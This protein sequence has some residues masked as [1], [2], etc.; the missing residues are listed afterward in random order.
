MAKARRI[1]VGTT[2][3][4][5]GTLSDFGCALER[6]IRNAT[7]ELNQ[8]NSA[9]Q[10]FELV[11]ADNQG[12]PEI[13]SRQAHDLVSKDGVTALIGGVGP[14]LGIP[15]SVVAEQLQVPAVITIVPIRAWTEATEASW[16]WSW[17]FFFDETQMTRTQF[18]AS[19]LVPT[20]RRV[21]LF[22]DLE[23]DGIVM[24]GMWASTANAHGYEIVYHAEFPVGAH[25]FGSHVAEA[26][27]ANADIVIGQLMPTEGGHLLD[28]IWDS[29]Y[30]PKLV[31]L[32]KCANSGEWGH[33]MKRRAD[34]VLV[35]GWFAEGMDMPDEA[36][37]IERFR[38]ANHGIDSTLATSVIGYTAV[39]L[40][41]DAVARGGSEDRAV[42]NRQIGKTDAAYPVG[43]I[44]FD[45]AHACALP[46]VMTQWRGRDTVLV[47]Q[48]D[49]TPGPA[50]IRAL[51]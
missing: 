31:F 34:G 13:A 22:T 36:E 3:P 26:K 47:M 28:A 20:N 5:T 9:E 39:R 6:G 18:L 43:R 8:R 44:R 49:G 48:A 11:V 23:E 30:Q 46:A 29:G 12:R 51:S 16:S 17:S 33:R 42:I 1:R 27:A 45:Q 7:E 24:G 14:R 21:A 10:M 2:L 38:I 4:L 19:D 15:V 32:E 37:F 25:D 41:G 35:A 40:L 50:A